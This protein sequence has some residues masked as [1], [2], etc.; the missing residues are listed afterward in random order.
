MY[1]HTHETYLVLSF[2]LGFSWLGCRQ[3]FLLSTNL[4][5][6][7]TLEPG[8]GLLLPPTT[9]PGSFLALIATLFFTTLAEIILALRLLHLLALL[10]GIRAFLPLAL[11]LAFRGFLAFQRFLEEG[12]VVAHALAMCALLGVQPQVLLLD[13][14]ALGLVQSG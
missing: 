9:T 7:T 6:E 14:R 1:V 8:S 5:L 2:L 10:H 12:G 11:G 4:G 13:V 3:S